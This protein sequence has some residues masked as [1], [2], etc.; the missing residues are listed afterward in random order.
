MGFS[1]SN[2][3]EVIFSDP[4]YAPMLVT[5]ELR[6]ILVRLLFLRAVGWKIVHMDWMTLEIG[7]RNVAFHHS[8]LVKFVNQRWNDSGNTSALMVPITSCI[9]YSVSFCPSI[10]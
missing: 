5:S 4:N 8:D 6:V 1:I 3:V 2:G 9:R 7:V 10:F